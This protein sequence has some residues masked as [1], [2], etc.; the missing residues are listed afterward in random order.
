M[1][2]KLFCD[3]N[4][5]YFVNKLGINNSSDLDYK[6]ALIMNGKVI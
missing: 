3:S 2:Y 6:E 1:K 4:P 5:N